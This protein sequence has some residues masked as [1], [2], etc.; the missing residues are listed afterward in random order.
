LLLLHSGGDKVVPVSNSRRLFEK[1][2][3]PKELHVFAG[4]EHRLR[5]HE[6]AVKVLISWLKNIIITTNV[7]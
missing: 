1:A 2:G 6:E 7:K 4:D 3:E 5:K